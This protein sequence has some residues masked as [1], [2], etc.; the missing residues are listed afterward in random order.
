MLP[1][2][3][4]RIATAALALCAA[5]PTQAD[6]AATAPLIEPAALQDD[7]RFALET[8]ERQHPDLAHSVTRAELE[9]QAGEIGQQLARP[10][11]QDEAWA[12]LAQ[13]NPV[14][15][16][17]HLVIGL[18]DWRQQAADA[19]GAG[20]GLFPFEVSLDAKGYPVI[21]S[22]LGGAAT[23][24]AGR[25]IVRINGHDSRAVATALLARV[26][27]DTPAFRRALLSQRW[28]LYYWKLHGAP[29]TF[30]LRLSGRK[31]AHRV[32]A[33]H[34]LPAVLQQEASFG[35]QFDCRVEPDGSA[36]LTVSSF[37]WEDTER[38]TRFTRDCFARMKAA[39][40]DRLVIDVSA[41]G[42]GDDALWKDGILR[43][44]ATQPYKHG[45]TYRKRERTG[46][47]STGAIETATEPAA[48]EPLRFS[49]K[50]TVL[51]GPL[52]YSSAV[53]F[54]NV[55]R[56]YCLATIEGT[57]NA[58]RTRQSGGVQS[59]TLPHTGLTL[60]YPRFVLDP[61]AGER[62]PDYLQPGAPG[63]CPAPGSPAA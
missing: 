46:A 9:R 33:G 34:V 63:P 17:G 24:L 29:A 28:W 26:H 13:L 32:P 35:R 57:G 2:L 27:G 56:D 36:R 3:T 15:A 8:I 11:N 47:I 50:V 5:L 7:L 19:I 58:A 59:V 4:T 18:P 43:Y 31:V 38:Y 20:T 6:S 1:R 39:A 53:L 37:Y 10:M 60:S 48:E 45:S 61:P 62:A 21:L 49:G 42:G 52:T 25:R 23:P 30:D 22:H 44:I 14:L 51:I 55:V 54:G 40:T 12:V 41:N 16:D